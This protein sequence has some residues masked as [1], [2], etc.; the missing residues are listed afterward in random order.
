M[1]HLH[2][3]I[4]L[5]QVSC[6]ANQLV[7]YSCYRIRFEPVLNDKLYKVMNSYI[8]M[9]GRFFTFIY[10]PVYGYGIK[11]LRNNICVYSCAWLYVAPKA[12]GTVVVE[13]LSDSSIGVSWNPPATYAT[14]FIKKYK[15]Q[16]VSFNRVA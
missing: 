9:L 8:S 4:H 12:P 11:Y 13:P 10:T 2:Y 16:D 15:V 6:S 3:Q 1:R 7:I 14:N 5:P